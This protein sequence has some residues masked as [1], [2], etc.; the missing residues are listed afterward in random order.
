MKWLGFLPEGERSFT[1]KE[2]EKSIDLFEDGAFPGSPEV[3][4]SKRVEKEE[5]IPLPILSLTDRTGGFANLLMEYGEKRVPFSRDL[6]VEKMWEGELLEG[7]FT[8]KQVGSSSYYCPLDQVVAAVTRL[9]EKGWRV[10][11]A[12]GREVVRQEK[13]S[14][15]ELRLERESIVAV[16]KVAF[17]E[18]EIEIEKVLSS[19]AKKEH[20]L[21]LGDGRVALVD[22]AKV[23]EE[24]GDA[25]E[26]LIAGKG[27]VPKV[28]FGLFG[29][30][31]G[32]TGD[33]RGAR[34]RSACAVFARGE[35]PR[36]F[37]AWGELRRLFTSVP[38]GGSR[39]AL[40]PLPDGAPRPARR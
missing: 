1:G 39:V 9:L 8:R 26:E 22:R 18:E 23:Q 36:A 13:L 24:L 40:V 33:A 29:S 2:R 31:L 32:K 34:F 17:A 20:F 19:L 14:A 37:F 25:T 16:G 30:L 6:P 7:A 15:L 12:Q 28:R 3:V 38:E 5:E 11:D 27:K 10:V 35:K 4:W 21:S